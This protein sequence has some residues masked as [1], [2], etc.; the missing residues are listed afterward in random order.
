VTLGKPAREKNH[1]DLLHKIVWTKTTVSMP[2]RTPSGRP[3]QLPKGTR[4][5]M[6]CGFVPGYDLL[7][8]DASGAKNHAVHD[9]AAWARALL[10]PSK[11]PTET[12]TVTVN[13]DTLRTQE[14]AIEV[15]EHAFV[16]RSREEQQ[17]RHGL[18]PS[19]KLIPLARSPLDAERKRKR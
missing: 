3:F 6:T 18:E 12:T 14:E 9:V 13:V 2:M 8:L 19:A 10:Y 7:E 17:R 15:Y 16:V 5:C 4:Y 1:G 11:P